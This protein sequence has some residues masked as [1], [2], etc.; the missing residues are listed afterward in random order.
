MIIILTLITLTFL[1]IRVAG[2]CSMSDDWVHVLDSFRISYEAYHELRMVSKG[3][4]P[5]I[6]R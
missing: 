1:T 6:W 3:H 2:M 4:L 5:P